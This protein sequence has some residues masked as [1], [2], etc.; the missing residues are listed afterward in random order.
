MPL[1][2]TMAPPGNPADGF[3]APKWDP[4]YQ[5]IPSLEISPF[6]C[7]IGQFG[8]GAEF[9]ALPEPVLLGIFCS[10]CSVV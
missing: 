6:L 7:V 3:I 2:S 8:A 9:K 4:L 5:A 1:S 10:P